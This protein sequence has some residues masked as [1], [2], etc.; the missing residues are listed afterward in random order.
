MRGALENISIITKPTEHTVMKQS[1]HTS[2]RPTPVY[3]IAIKLAFDG[4]DNHAFWPLKKV[5]LLTLLV[6][7]VVNAN[8]TIFS[9]M[10]IAKRTNSIM[11]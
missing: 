8:F 4:I 10:N 5:R 7:L 6:C 2:G 9:T 1:R 3:Y 11:S